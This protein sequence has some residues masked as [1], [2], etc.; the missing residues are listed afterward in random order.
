MSIKSLHASCFGLNPKPRQMV[1]YSKRDKLKKSSEA[2]Y[3]RRLEWKE[4]FNDPA[5]N[6]VDEMMLVG[7]SL[8]PD[9]YSISQS[10]VLFLE[11]AFFLHCNLSCLQ[12]CDLDGKV[13]QTDDIWRKFCKLKETFVEC[14]VSYLYLKSKNWV[15]KSGIKF[16]GD[17]REYNEANAVKIL[18]L[19]FPISSAVQ[20]ES[21]TLSRFVHHHRIQNGSQVQ[22]RIS[23][24]RENC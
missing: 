5:E 4:K 9:P 2:E 3:N 20:A 14:F 6:T 22:P 7:D 12:I 21:S 1:T 19:Y 13:L 15:I 24:K 16:G 17:F 10:L 23:H 8:V 18:I 11:E